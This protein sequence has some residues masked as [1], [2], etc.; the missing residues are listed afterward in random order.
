MEGAS[1][2]PKEVAVLVMLA[3]LLSGA[4]VI[5]AEDPSN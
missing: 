1:L 2:R 4:P 5:G 3:L